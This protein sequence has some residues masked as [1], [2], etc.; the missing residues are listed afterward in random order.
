MDTLPVVSPKQLVAL[1]FDLPVPCRVEGLAGLDDLVCLKALRVVPDR[2]MVFLA[3]NADTR[4][5]VKLINGQRRQTQQCAA[6]EKGI[7][8]LEG[9]AVTTQKIYASYWGVSTDIGYIATRYIENAQ[10]LLATWLQQSDDQRVTLLEQVMLVF[11]KM[12]NGGVF[13]E[14]AHL[15][16]FLCRE[17]EIFV[18][19]GASI[20][21]EHLGKAL[22]HEQ[23]LD[24]LVVLFGQLYPH[25]DPLIPAALDYYLQH[26]TGLSEPITLPALEKQLAAFRKER[27]AKYLKKVFRESTEHVCFQDKHQFVVFARVHDTPMA[28][29]FARDPDAFVEQGEM[30]KQGNSSTVVQTV[31]NDKPCVIKRYNIKSMPHAIRRSVQTSRAWVSWRNAH[32][33]RALGIPTPEPVLLYE[34]RWGAM[35]STAYFISEQVTDATQLSELIEQGLSK[36]EGLKLFE[37]FFDALKRSQ[38]THGDM[39]ATNFFVRDDVVIPIDLDGMSWHQSVS[40]FEQA[41]AE[42][43]KRFIQN[44]SA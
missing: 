2:R 35:R 8:A 30:L 43:Q 19:D 38:V 39:K 31:F 41:F 4:I 12:H 42:D 5:V 10:D 37:R 33:L 20:N 25:F 24:N 6:E 40:S 16:N 14:D 9:L 7:I 29:E 15:N 1:G 23:S 21:T 27:L 28:R 26:R 11:C 44:W 17:G 18:I 32:M 3:T 22:D 13:Q 34:A 36:D